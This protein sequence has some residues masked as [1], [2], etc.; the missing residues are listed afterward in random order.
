MAR[1]L[2]GTDDGRQCVH[3]PALAFVQQHDF[4]G[5]GRSLVERLFD[6]RGLLVAPVVRIER[7]EHGGEAS[8]QA[9]EHRAHGHRTVRRSYE[10][11]TRRAWREQRVRALELFRELALGQLGETTMG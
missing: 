10:R 5:S 11:A 9:R 2:E 6:L 4:A 8:A 1:L 3:G 7:P